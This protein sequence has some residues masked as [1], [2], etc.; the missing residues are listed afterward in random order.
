MFGLFKRDPSRA[1]LRIPLELFSASAAGGSH[2]CNILNGAGLKGKFR[3]EDI[4]TEVCAV[5]VRTVISAMSRAD[6][7]SGSIDERFD[8]AAHFLLENLPNVLNRLKEPAFVKKLTAQGFAAD[9]LMLLGKLLIADKIYHLAA[10]YY[11]CSGLEVSNEDV[12]KF[13]RKYNPKILSLG[14]ED[15]SNAVF[16]YI[17]RCVRLSHLEDITD[18][19]FRTSH[20]G[21]FNDTLM[22]SLLELER[23]VER[24][25]A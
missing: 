15:R 9:D 1:K 12:L 24:L 3:R 14:S 17:V 5:H 23:T 2:A 16:A 4:F 13:G 11:M 10:S 7:L 21:R 22:E 18:V 19:G 20:I 25:L 8:K 6:G